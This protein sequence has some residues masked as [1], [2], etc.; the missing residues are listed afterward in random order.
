MKDKG[1]KNEFDNDDQNK[2]FEKVIKI[3]R[4]TKVVK[5]GKRLA[6][7]AFVIVGDK[8]GRTS[9]GL[10]KAREV[11][12]S[13]KK[14]IDRANKDLKSYNI[15]NGTIP[16]EIIGKFSSSLVIMRPASE[17]TGIIAGGAAKTIFES[18]GVRN[19]VAKV[20]GSR[21][22]LNVAKATVDGLSKL[23]NLNEVQEARGIQIPVFKGK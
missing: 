13:I 23:L 15:V 18:L 9:F 5:G 1:K 17:G 20:H 22:P 4:V 3:D 8:N 2:N 10:G 14:A 19:I 7:R 11:P 21:N 12:R 6:F 16:H